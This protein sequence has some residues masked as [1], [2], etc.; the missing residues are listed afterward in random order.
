M[1]RGYFMNPTHPDPFGLL[2]FEYGFAEIFASCAKIPL[3]HWPHWVRLGT[4][5]SVLAVSL[6]Y[7]SQA[8]R[9]LWLRKF[10]PLFFSWL[11][12]TWIR[13]SWDKS[14]S[15][16]VSRFWRHFTAIKKKKIMLTLQFQWHRGVKLCG[17]IDTAQF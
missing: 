1:P 9:C 8:R 14:L 2:I 17:S 13:D 12:L 5:G 7:R 4:A 10:P 15:W 3:C 16:R 6:I 11:K